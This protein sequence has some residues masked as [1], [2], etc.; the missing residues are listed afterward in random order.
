MLCTSLDWREVWGRM[1]TCIYM[2]E[3]LHCSPETT[4]T[5]LTGYTPI[6]KK[7]FIKVG[8]IKNTIQRIVFV[9]GKNPDAGKDGRQEEEVETG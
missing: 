2:V 8:K 5:L 7:K 1:D 9:I 6:Q 4:T 3:F